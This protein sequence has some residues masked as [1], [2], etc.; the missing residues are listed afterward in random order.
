M[1]QLARITGIRIPEAIARRRAGQEHTII[2]V[3]NSGK[4]E[5][6]G[7]SLTRVYAASV[8]LTNAIK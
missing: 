5:R 1:R 4:A 3:E 2:G 7:E 6:E 8:T